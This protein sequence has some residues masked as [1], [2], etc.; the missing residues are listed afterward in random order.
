MQDITKQNNN[1]R[2]VSFQALSVDEGQRL[3]GVFAWLIE[4]DKKQN[5][6]LYQL[7]NSKK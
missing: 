4:K 5:P 3:T 7:N 2:E 1:Q 6:A